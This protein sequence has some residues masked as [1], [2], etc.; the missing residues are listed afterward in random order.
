MD[1][2]HGKQDTQQ[3]PE[4]LDLPDELNLENEDGKA[5]GDEKDDEHTE[6]IHTTKI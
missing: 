1:P 3:E 4:S 5:S 2:Y 6:G